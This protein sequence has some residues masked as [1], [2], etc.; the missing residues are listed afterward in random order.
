MIYIV[1]K[2]VSSLDFFSNCYYSISVT[3]QWCR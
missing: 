3:Q 2:R 1:S